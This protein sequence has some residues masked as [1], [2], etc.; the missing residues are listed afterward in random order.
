MFLWSCDIVKNGILIIDKES[1]VTSRDVVNQ[2]C[3]KLSTK[4][5]GHT[6][7]LDPLATGV[8]VL[9]VGEATK[10]VPYLTSAEKEYVAEVLLGVE[11]DTLDITG[12]ILK[13]EEVVVKEED[14]QRVFLEFPKKYEQEVPKFSAVHVDGKRLYEYAREDEEVDLPKREVE[15]KE[16]ELLSFEN[17]DG[18]KY[19]SFRTVVSKGTYIRS[20]IRDIGDALGCSCCMFN[21]RRTRQGIFKIEDAKLARDVVLGDVVPMVKALSDYPVY[22]VESDEELFKV[23]NGCKLNK[24]LDGVTC[25]VDKEGH[26]LAIYDKIEEGI[27]RP[28][29]VFH[30]N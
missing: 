7:T 14:V 10:L 29:K 19:F 22:V 11:T 24:N 8:L 4:K 26:L 6:G 20:L 3:R 13:K 12:N 2:V 28:L 18:E 21:L 16:L 30:D 9:A 25:F 15:I 27:V 5:I 1:G 17:K 23:Q